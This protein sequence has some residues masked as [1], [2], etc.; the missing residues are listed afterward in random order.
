M[1]A[2]EKSRG[3]FGTSSRPYKSK[4][5]PIATEALV[6]MIGISFSLGMTGIAPKYLSNRHSLPQPGGFDSADIGGSMLI[7]DQPAERLARRAEKDRP[8]FH[9]LVYLVVSISI[10]LLAAPTVSLAQGDS[11]ATSSRAAREDA[12]RAIPWQQ[13]GPNERG[14]VQTVVQNA[15]IFRRLPTRVIDCDPQVFSFLMRHPEVVAEIWRVMGVSQ[16]RIDRLP[17]GSFRGD[18]GIGTTG[19]VRFLASGWGPGANIMALVLA[20]GA[21][22]GKPFVMPLK[23]RSV[24]LVRSAGVREHNG[25]YYVTVRADAFVQVE[26]M[27]VELVAKTV[28]PW[29]NATADRNLIDTLTFVSNFS[30][31]AERNPD[32]M[33]RLAA[34]LTSIDEPTRRELVQ[35]CAQTAHRYSKQDPP[36]RSGSPAVALYSDR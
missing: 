5:T 4:V 22:E 21:Y 20:D 8:A 7:L 28:Q 1:C 19:T 27:A 18:D 32:G 15:G 23:A 36:S 12:A 30:R 24:M 26:Q 35:I 31:T 14:A 6:P 17:D 25:R 9:A 33:M 3:I 16:M 34:R 10:C 2:V 29:V 13:L 11:D